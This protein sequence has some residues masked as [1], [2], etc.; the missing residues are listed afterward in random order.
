MPCTSTLSGCRSAAAQ[1]L[2]NHGKAMKAM[3]DK[4]GKY[5]GPVVFSEGAHW[6]TDE[7]GHPDTKQ[8][9]LWVADQP[10]EAAAAEPSG[11]SNEAGGYYRWATADDPT[12][13]DAYHVN[14]VELQFEGEAPIEVTEAEAA[15]VKAYLES[16]RGGAEA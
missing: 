12:H 16:V 11:E 4:E 1:A 10:H 6:P 13:F 15:G 5:D 14:H 9:L 8:R 7:D 3:A 2:T